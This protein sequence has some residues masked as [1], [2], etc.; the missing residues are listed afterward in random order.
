[1]VCSLRQKCTFLMWPTRSSCSNTR[2]PTYPACTTLLIISHAWLL[3]FGYDI[4]MLTC[5]ASDQDCRVRERRAYAVGIY[6]DR[7]NLKSDSTK[8]L[9]ST[10]K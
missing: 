3:T 7:A 8:P 5:R 10:L 6:R 2:L 1:M 9:Y 4:C